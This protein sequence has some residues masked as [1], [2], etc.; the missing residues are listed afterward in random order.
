MAY[1]LL[2]LWRPTSCNMKI[3]YNHHASLLVQEWSFSTA[4]QQAV[5]R[6][7]NNVRLAPQQITGVV[8]G[9]VKEY[10]EQKTELK[11]FLLCN[12][13]PLNGLVIICCR[14]KHSGL[15]STD[16]TEHKTINYG[17]CALCSVKNTPY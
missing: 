14:Y 5:H 1:Q 6:N 15:Y 8:D 7:P 11:K 16:L 9:Y 12:C 2:L 3:F 13:I 17:I 10:R 4:N